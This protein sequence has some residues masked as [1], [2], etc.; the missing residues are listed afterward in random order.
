V[1]QGTVKRLTHSVCKINLNQVGE[2][3]NKCALLLSRA[4]GLL[5][6]VLAVYDKILHGKRKNSQ[7]FNSKY[8]ILSSSAKVLIQSSKE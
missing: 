6:A 4:K 1:G 5:S 2:K 7:A 8:I 3:P